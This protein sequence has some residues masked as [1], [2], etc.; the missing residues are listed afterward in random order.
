MQY[1]WDTVETVQ[2]GIGFSYFEWPHLVWLAVFV[3]VV[4]VL[5]F[6]YRRLGST[7]RQRMRWAMAAGLVLNEL[8]KLVGL[9]I[10]GTWLPKYLPLHIC[11]INIFL[12]ALHSVRPSQL[13]N[14][15]LY[16]VGIPTA[17]IALL[18]PSWNELPQCN[19]MNIH[20]F[21]VHIQL[22][23]YPLVLT[24]GGDIRPQLRYLWKDLL[25]AVGMAIPVY[26]INLLLETN[27]MFL[28]E[29]EAGN[30]LLWFE[31]T[32]GN[33]LWG[34]PILGI[35]VLIGMYALAWPIWRRKKSEAQSL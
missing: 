2:D 12:I 24:L 33:H 20:S 4:A 23:A 18:V 5:S 35:L 7:G 16:A 31:K 6:V 17:I 22:A 14:N 9:F 21:T 25:F 26:G 10:G 34:I 32:M 1:F 11:S 27:F 19:F 8:F 15:Y 13:L 30:P 29:A 28:M 3:L